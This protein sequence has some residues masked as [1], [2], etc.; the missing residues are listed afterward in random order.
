VEELLY[1]HCFIE[2]KLLLI[3][4]T[5][6]N[7]A[8]GASVSCSGYWCYGSF[9][10]PGFCH[11]SSTC[12]LASNYYSN[13][14]QAYNSYSTNCLTDGTSCSTCTSF[15]NCGWCSATNT[16]GDRICNSCSSSFT[17]SCGPGSSGLSGLSGS[18]SLAVDE[19]D[20]AKE[21]VTSGT[22]ASVVV[23]AVAGLVMIAAAV[24]KPCKAPATPHMEAW[25]PRA[26]RSFNC[27][28]AGVFFRSL[29]FVIGL[30]APAIPWLSVGASA[31][32]SSVVGGSGAGLSFIFDTINI[33]YKQVVN[34]VPTTVTIPN[35]LTISG[36]I[37]A[38]IALV[39]FVF[40]SL[41]LAWAALCRLSALVKYGSAP[42]TA[43]CV[44]GMPAIQGLGWFGTILFVIGM[45]IDWF[46]F[47]VIRMLINVSGVGPGGNLAAA[48]VALIFLSSIC[49]SVAAGCSC[50]GGQLGPLPGVGNS[51][52]NCCCPER[53]PD[54]GPEG[55][56]VP[57]GGLKVAV[58]ENKGGAAV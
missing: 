27:L 49:I 54:M 14:A 6:I 20:E 43:G 19:L 30:A 10:C 53:N 28:A 36:A 34:G 35:P 9:S 38:Y 50:C 18:F 3:F 40:P 41:I 31:S 7:G 8:A 45:A 29:G 25:K 57:A 52:G 13:S 12:G 55:E 56:P 48:A 11:V 46:F 2:M 39:A 24:F 23:G 16:C 44:P 15:S 47:G 1:A 37:I 26:K 51:K 33:S 42:P 5:A 4:I 21:K 22:A 17:S 58:P 32:F